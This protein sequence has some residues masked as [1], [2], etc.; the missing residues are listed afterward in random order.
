MHG[1][2]EKCICGLVRLQRDNT[3]DTTIKHVTYAL[4]VSSESVTLSGVLNCAG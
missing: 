2:G 4:H 1:I 3:A